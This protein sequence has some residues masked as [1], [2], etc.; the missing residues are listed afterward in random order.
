MLHVNADE[1][2]YQRHRLVRAGVIAQGTRFKEWCDREGI[3]LQNADKALLN[4][5]KGP[6]TAE[7]V[8]R[9]LEAATPW[10]NPLL[11]WRPGN[12]WRRLHPFR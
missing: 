4:E 8:V 2:Y 1:D 12:A 3:A 7:P 11:S 5:W 10:P 9:I 6:K